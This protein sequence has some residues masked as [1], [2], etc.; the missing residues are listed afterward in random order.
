MRS[1]VSSSWALLADA[2]VDAA[3]GSRVAGRAGLVGDD[4]LDGD[5]QP[6]AVL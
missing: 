1:I 5:E 4:R 3:A 6:P 2:K